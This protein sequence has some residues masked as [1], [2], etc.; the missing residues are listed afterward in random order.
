MSLTLQRAVIRGL[1]T[2]AV[3]LLIVTDAAASGLAALAGSVLIPASVAACLS[4]LRA[5]REG[6]P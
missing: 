2:V 5:A 4:C 6:Q 3:L 1:I